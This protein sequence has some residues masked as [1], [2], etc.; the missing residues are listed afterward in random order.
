MSCLKNKGFFNLCNVSFGWQAIRLGLKPCDGYWKYWERWRR[1]EEWQTACFPHVESTAWKKSC[2]LS[3]SN[4]C[5]CFWRESIL[6]LQAKRRSWLK[7]GALG[8]SLVRLA[9]CWAPQLF[10]SGWLKFRKKRTGE[11][12]SER[13]L[14]M[15]ISSTDIK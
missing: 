6:I 8:H 9:S 11:N 3:S 2:N 10:W 14:S 12:V 1:L 13:D 15:F 5:Q 4:C 7:F